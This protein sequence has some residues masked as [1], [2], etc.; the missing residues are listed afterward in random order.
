MNLIQYKQKPPVIG[1]MLQEWRTHCKPQMSIVTGKG[2]NILAMEA[3]E[4]F[5]YLNCSSSTST[6]QVLS[7]PSFSHEKTRGAK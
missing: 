5:L 4:D 2:R 6:L 1:R 7:F 3:V